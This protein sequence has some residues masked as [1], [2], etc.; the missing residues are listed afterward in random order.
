MRKLLV[1]LLA[2]FTAHASATVATLTVPVLAPHLQAI[3]GVDGRYVGLYSSA[4][5]FGSLITTILSVHFIKSIGALNSLKS[6]LVLSIAGMV[7]LSFHNPFAFFASALIIGFSFGPMNPVSSVILAGTCP[8][9]M[10][11]RVFSIKQGAV[12]FGA[13]ITA[14]A[15]PFVHAGYGMPVVVAMVIAVCLAGL[16]LV[17]LT[18]AVFDEKPVPSVQKRSARTFLSD[19][20]RTFQHRDL[21]RIVFVST[22]LAGVQFTFAPTLIYVLVSHGGYSAGH[23][24]GVLSAVMLLSFFM[25]PVFGAMA[26]LL[27]ARAVVVGISAS[28]GVFSVIFPFL[29]GG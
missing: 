12:P 28:V 18:G 26:D 7:A 6:T 21:R 1:A 8:P 2:T 11:G 29:L 20:V 10:R 17:Q 22:G 5:Y 3:Y 9:R 14:L 4:V 24:G 25:R 27:G 16:L 23:A 15:V 13:G 19:F